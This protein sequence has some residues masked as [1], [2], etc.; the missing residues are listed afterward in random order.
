MMKMMKMTRMVR[1]MTADGTRTASIVPSLP[2][3]SDPLVF[4][5]GFRVQGL[6]FRV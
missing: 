3:P 4:G 1:I 2:V 5:L 6:G